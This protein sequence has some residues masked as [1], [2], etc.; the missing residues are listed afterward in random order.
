MFVCYI[1]STNTVSSML[2]HKYERLRIKHVQFIILKG[3]KEQNSKG[4]ALE[5]IIFYVNSNT[6]LIMA[7][8]DKN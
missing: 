1:S 4:I 2:I 3:K 5:G 6:D 8:N 7:N